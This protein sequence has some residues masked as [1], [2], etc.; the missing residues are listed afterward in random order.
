V[1]F[2]PLPEYVADEYD[3]MRKMKFEEMKRNRERQGEQMPFRIGACNDTS[4]VS[5]LLRSSCDSRFVDVPEELRALPLRAALRHTGKCHQCVAW[6]QRVVPQRA[7]SKPKIAQAQHEAPF[8][9]P[10]PSKKGHA[11]TMSPF[12]EH[13][14]ER[15][16][17]A[18]RRPKNEEETAPPPWK[19]NSTSRSP[20]NPMPSVVMNTRNLKASFPS[21]FARPRV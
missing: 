7:L 10:N 15:P 6:W 17:E 8:R 4:K 2:S 5:P 20:A 12:P 3:A 16:V 11:S 9:P 21:A 19:P 14:P 1:L 18:K 13:I